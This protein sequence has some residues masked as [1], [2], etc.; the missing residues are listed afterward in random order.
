MVSREINASSVPQSRWLLA[1]EWA[2]V[3]FSWQARIRPAEMKWDAM[4][5]DA[6]AKWLRKLRTPK[7]NT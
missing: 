5:W 7:K 1:A 3:T 2:R 4:V 6:Q